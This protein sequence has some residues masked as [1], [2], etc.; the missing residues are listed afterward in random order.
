VVA[1]VG[2]RHAALPKLLC[3]IRLG[4]AYKHLRAPS[5]LLTRTMVGS[6]WTRITS[7]MRTRAKQEFESFVGRRHASPGCQY[8]AS[9]GVAPT[10]SG[11]D[12]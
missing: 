11:V 10:I 2:Q 1:T 4:A 8:V 9:V 12:A 6:R 5:W 3:H 7:L